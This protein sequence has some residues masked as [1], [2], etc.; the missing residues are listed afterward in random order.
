MLSASIGSRLKQSFTNI[1]NIARVTPVESLGLIEEEEDAETP[2]E[3]IANKKRR[4]G[5]AA[6]ATGLG[7]LIFGLLVVG[8]AFALTNT[9]EYFQGR[10]GI[11]REKGRKR[12]MRGNTIRGE[13]FAYITKVTPLLVTAAFAETNIVAGNHGVAYF[14]PIMGHVQNGT[15]VNCCTNYKL[16]KDPL[17]KSSID[18]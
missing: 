17:V 16:L 2:A 14:P 4:A 5:C 15:N 7:L 10:G 13:I 12:R 1:A 9:S 6:G 8:A 18:M 3:R 11:G